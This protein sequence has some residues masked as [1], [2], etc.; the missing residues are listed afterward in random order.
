M[1]KALKYR[2]YPIKKQKELLDTTLK[3]CCWLYNTALEQRKEVYRIT[4]KSISCYEQKKELPSIKTEFPNYNNIHSQV[5]QD[6]IERVDAAFQ[7]FFRRL[8][9][10]NGKAGY[11]RYKSHK[12]YDSFTYP[13][14]G[15]KLT[16]DKKR[17]E[18]SKIGLIR[19]KLHRPIPENAKIKACTIKR[20]GEQWYAVF[21]CDINIPT[22]EKKPVKT[23]V[24]IDLGVSN[25][26]VLSNGEE[27]ENPK[28]L[29]Q[30][31]EKLKEVQSKYSKGKSKKLK[32]Q[33]VKLHRKVANQ[34]KDFQHKL[35]RKLVDTYDLIAYEDLSIKQMIEDNEYNLQKHIS[36]ASWGRFIA[37]LVYKAEEAGKYC[38]AVNPRGTTQRCS[39]CGEVVSKTLS[40]REHNCQN[41]GFRTTR[42]HNASINI[43]RSGAGL[44]MNQSPKPIPFKVG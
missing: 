42:D 28:Y 40:E 12:R 30:S 20:E 16:K 13:Q 22:P 17:I 31:E 18:L 39:S 29:K 23:A 15:F 1:K 37:M 14:S 41:C 27:I 9:A 19:I 26:A 21:S 3:L 4:Q 44:V 5:L 6:V 33:L 7:G 35:S 10:N 38:I 11:P 32:R 43:L 2:I 36:D 34:R 25:Y 24:G 8:K